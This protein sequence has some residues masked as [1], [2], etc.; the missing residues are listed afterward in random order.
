MLEEMSERERR[1][2]V[3]SL[4]SHPGS[5][6]RKKAAKP[7]KTRKPAEAGQDGAVGEGAEGSGASDESGSEGSLADSEEMFDD[8]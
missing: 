5:Y 8:D 4:R 2:S 1:R 7:K 6:L 3:G